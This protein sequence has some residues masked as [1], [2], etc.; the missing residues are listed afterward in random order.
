MAAMYDLLMQ[1]PVFQGISKDRMTHILEVIPFEFHTFR[2]GEIISRGGD[3]IQGA[4]FL[5]SGRIR[6]VT[7]I[8]NNRMNIT[9]MFD[10]PYTFSLHHM[11]GAD[12]KAHSTMYA[13][14]EKAGIMILRKSDFLH[15][16]QEND[17]ALI[18][19]LN[20]LC[21]R[22][23]KQ[24]KALD[25]SGESDPILRLASW[26]LAFSERSAAEV[27]F[28]GA[29]KDLCELLQLEAPAL[30]RCVA[31]LEGQHLVESLSGRLKLLDRYGLRSLVKNKSARK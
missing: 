8:F 24:H 3:M 12:V 16:L 11:F 4:T 14:T 22:A 15:I 5:L 23:Q 6:L 13:E 10:A 17:I 31:S 27:T 28:E 7:P 9:Q 21:T 25:F 19:V 20:M 18:N 26:M 2:K 30:W 1:L 29:E